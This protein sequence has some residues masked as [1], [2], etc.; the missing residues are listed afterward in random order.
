MGHWPLAVSLTLGALLLWA[1][2]P[3]LA[4]AARKWVVDPQYSHGYL[5]PAFAGLL[6]WLRRGTLAQGALRPSWWGVGILL[7]GAALHLLGAYYYAE[8]LEDISF[9]VGLVGVSLCAGGRQCLKWS[10]PSIAFLV[11]MMPLPHRLEVALGGPLQRIAVLASTYILQTLGFPAVAEGNVIFMEEAQIG[12]VAACSGLGMMMTFGALATAVALVVRRP[13]LDR[14]VIVASAAPI[15]LL[16]NLVRI[17]VT[18]I[19][20]DTVG[21]DWANLVFHDL[22]GWL[23]MPLALALLWLELG[24][25]AR[26]FVEVP[27]SDPGLLSPLGDE[28]GPTSNAALART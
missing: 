5:V 22:A 15:A 18:S 9:L 26:L 3:T 16:A 27:R 8:Y 10:G 25:L 21:V 20:A 23:M 24:L 19:L 11:F 6:L 7:L 4:G 2:A 13:L 17:T 14:L 12:V 28:P 1:Y